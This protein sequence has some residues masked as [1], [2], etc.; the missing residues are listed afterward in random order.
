MNIT[1]SELKILK[2]LWE[3][4]CL[5][6]MQI[7]ERLKSETGWSKQAVISFL[8]RMEIKK[9]VSHEERGRAKYYIALVKKESIAKDERTSFLHKF[10]QGKLGLMISAMAEENALSSNDIS[11]LKEL[12]ERLQKERD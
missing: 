2:L 6:T 1:E 3:E 12:L 9:L 8:R 4:G 11:D 5:S 7:T 10:Y